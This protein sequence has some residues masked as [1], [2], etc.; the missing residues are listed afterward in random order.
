MRRF[1]A[2]MSPQRRQNILDEAYALGRLGSHR[3]PDSAHC[4][5]LSDTAVMKALDA[6]ARGLSEFEQERAK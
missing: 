6:N 1:I 3:L 4:E 2:Q 5:E